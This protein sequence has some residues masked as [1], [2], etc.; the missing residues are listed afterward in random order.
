[1]PKPSYV[2]T[3]E[4]VR[5]IQKRFCQKYEKPSFSQEDM[6][7]EANLHRDTIRKLL[8]RTGGVNRKTLEDLCSPLDWDIENLTNGCDYILR[9]P[10][11]I[12]GRYTIIK[13]LGRGEFGDTY[14]SEDFSPTGKPQCVVI[15]QLSIQ[16]SETAKKSQ[17][18]NV[19]ALL[20]LNNHNKLLN[21]HNNQIAKLLHYFDE[22]DYLYLVYEFI[23]GNTLSQ[24]LIEGQPWISSQVINM[25]QENLKILEFIHERNIIHRNINPKNLIRRSLDKKIILINFSSLKE[26]SGGQT[27]T[28]AGTQGYMAPEQANGLAFACSDIYA[29]GT[30]GIQAITGINPT[31]FKVNSEGKI[32]WRDKAKV[33]LKFAD[34]LDKMVRYNFQERYQSAA[35]ALQDFQNL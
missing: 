17:I 18:R 31:Q 14:L 29:V 16:G 27:R 4:G 6:A 33:N 22:K 21:N 15:K 5:K 25:L 35:D 34:I 11:I 28:F 9:P 12:G 10:T 7:V 13:H 2:L 19:N 3:E 32:I 8:N 24:E 23:Q 20:S 30:L 1:M 26:I